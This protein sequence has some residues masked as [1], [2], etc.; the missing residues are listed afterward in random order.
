MGL[1]TFFITAATRLTSMSRKKDGHQDPQAIFDR[2]AGKIMILESRKNYYYLLIS[3]RVDHLITVKE[4]LGTKGSISQADPLESLGHV[5]SLAASFTHARHKSKKANITALADSLDREGPCCFAY[6][7]RQHFIVR[8]AYNST[9][10]VSLWN[11]STFIRDDPEKCGLVAARKFRVPLS[12]F[13]VV[14]YF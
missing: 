3:F 11:V 7:N 10:G 9:I 12:S 2:I 1:I 8:R 4:I 6:L 5:A 14:A 13:G